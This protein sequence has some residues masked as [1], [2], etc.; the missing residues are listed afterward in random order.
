MPASQAAITLA[1]AACA[2]RIPRACSQA[3]NG[4]NPA[5]DGVSE[6]KI[7]N[8]KKIVPMK[9]PPG[10]SAN[11]VG[12]TSNTN[13]GPPAGSIWKRNTSGNTSI[14]AITETSRIEPLTKSAGR[15]SGARRDI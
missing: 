13:A 8:T 4:S 1:T 6:A 15:T 12:K 9:R 7:S 5:R 10:M 11:A 14:V 3:T 2:R